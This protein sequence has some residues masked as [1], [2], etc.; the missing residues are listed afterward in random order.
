[1]RIFKWV[2]TIIFF[3]MIV[4]GAVFLFYINDYYHVSDSA[5]Q[6][7]QEMT[8]DDDGDLYFK[9]E[10]DR[11]FIIYPGNR[12]D[13][14]AYAGLAQDL[15]FEGDEVV[16]ARAPYRLTFLDDNLADRIIAKNKEIKEWYIVG[17]D[18]GGY[19]ASRYI[20]VNPQKVEGVVFLGSYP[21]ANLE[22]IDIRS[23]AIVG[24]RDELVNRMKIES[25]DYYPQDSSVVSLAGGNH[26]YFGDYGLLNGDDPA[27]ISPGE[28][29]RQTAKEILDWVD[30]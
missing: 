13:I 1:M 7:S 12:V 17:I 8:E 5:M 19:A 25:N 4:A 21:R 2:L 11:G 14:R 16:I 20:A 29:Q 10:T 24:D 9:G 6:I 28:Q 22:E 23:L 27:L 26:S 30:S 15:N 3:I 18:Q